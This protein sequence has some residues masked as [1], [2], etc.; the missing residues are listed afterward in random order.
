MQ[1][2]CSSVSIFYRPAH[3]NLS[4]HKYFIYVVLLFC[5]HL[6]ADDLPS[7]V[8][9]PI[10]IETIQHENSYNIQFSSSASRTSANS[11]ETPYSV[12][13]ISKQILQDSVF[14]RLE[15]SAVFASGV[16][17]SSN[18]S[19]LNTDLIIRG[20]STQGATFLNGV[21]DN[22]RFQVRDPALIDRIE[23]LKGHSA[24][25]YG[26]GSP[27]GSV[28]YI[29]KKPLAK[30]RH[31]FS[32]EAGNY[33]YYRLVADSTGTVN[34]RQDLLYRVISVGQL[35]NDFRDNIE[36]DRATIAPSLSWHYADSGIFN[37]ELEYSYEN[38]PFRFDNVYTQKQIVYD[39]SYVD[40][41]AQSDRHHWR[42]S[43]SLKQA[44]SDNWSVNLSANY[45]H[46]ERHDVLFGF[47]TFINDNTL[48]GY[49]RDIHDHYDQLNLRFELQGNIEILGSQ[50]HTI[51]G[52]E[53]NA[54][55]ARLNSNRNIGGFSLDVY[56]PD[57]NHPVPTT[58]VLDR[59]TDIVEYGYY[60][61]DKIDLSKFMHI[62]AGI[63][64]SEFSAE[65]VQ[66]ER[67]SQLTDNNALNYNAGI[68]FTPLDNVAAYFGYSESFQPNYGLSRSGGFLPAKRGQLYELGI[69]SHFFNNRIGLSTAIYEL[70]QNN[71]TARDPVDPDFLISNGKIKSEGFEADLSGNL[72]EH[73]SVHA[74]YSLTRTRFT[75]HN[76]YQGNSFRSTPS[77]S[78]TLW[79][80]Y[81]LPAIFDNNQFAVGGGL[82]FV[83]RRQGDDAN[84]FELPGYIRSDLFVSYK[85]KQL[86]LQLNIENI[87]DK[88]YVSTSIYDD[89]VVQGNRRLIRASASV[90]LF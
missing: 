51:L 41:R 23:I 73:L 85:L 84:S 31:Q 57:F 81:Q 3:F 80:K 86:S 37:L 69:K 52:F 30:S 2:F 10:L 36:N 9:S 56:Q 76:S 62:F 40:P 50:H 35:A 46:T 89:T 75:E 53:R 74:N 13:V 16:E 54:S 29:S 17:A 70:T 67:F 11:L 27:G 24:V 47:F 78:G 79:S 6:S 58:T 22:Q 1:K 5:S 38:Q 88:R 12:S 77:Q 20:F 8:L 43:S 66:N 59:D 72:N 39:K 18:Q 15:D 7:Q 33:D 71:L 68:S 65:R 61:H 19:G 63:R 48:S 49:Y 60:L 42:V 14:N 55:D 87:L 90:E 26:S 34:N 82:I 21:Q 44:L 32:I 64:Y 45:F 28:N 4:I 83:G 25:L